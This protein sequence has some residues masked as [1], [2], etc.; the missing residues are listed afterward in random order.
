MA[1]AKDTI[2]I[3]TTCPNRST[4]ESIA[5]LL[6]EQRYAACVNVI[7]AIQSIYCW[8]DKIESDEETMLVIKTTKQRYGDIESTIQS[9]HPYDIPEVIALDIEKGAHSYLSWITQSTKTAS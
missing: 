2:V 9:N 3:L 7:D 1:T 4:A 8:K 5:R 6:V